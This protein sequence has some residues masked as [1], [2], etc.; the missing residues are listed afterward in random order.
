[1]GIIT[2]RAV[3][4]DRR[5]DGE[6]SPNSGPAAS[7]APDSAEGPSGVDRAGAIRFDRY[8]LDLERGCLMAGDE[9][10]ALRPKSF[11][12]LRYLASNPGRLVSKDELLAAVWPNV[13]VTEDSLVQ[14]VAELRRALCDRDQRLIRTMPRRGYRFESTTALELSPAASQVAEPPV[15]SE[16]IDEST[17]HGRQPAGT[18][19]KRR[20]PVLVAIGALAALATTI[21]IG[22]WWFGLQGR[23]TSA[24]PLSII[25][26]PFENF[27]DDPGQEHFANGVSSDLTTELSRLPGMFVISHATARTL[28]GKDIDPGQI[29]RELNVRY[30]LE[31]S[32][33]QTREQMRINV[34]LVDT[35]SGASAWADRFERERDQ[36]HPWGDEVIGRIAMTLYFRLTRLEGD[37]ALRER[38]DDPEAFDLTTRGWAL[39]YTANKRET[40]H[41]ARALFEQALEK[42][43]RAVN[44]LV[45][46]GWTSAVSVLDDWSASP[47]ADLATAESAV[48]QALALDPNHFIAHH[49]RGLTHRLRQRTQAARDA[50][51]TAVA[52]NPNWA[53]GYAQLAATALELGRPEET[54]AAIE[55]AIR[56]SPR[57]PNLGPWLANA[58]KAELHL[59]HYDE[60]ASWLARAIETGTPS[61]RNDA[62]LAAALALAGRADEARTALAKFRQMKPSAT[63][64]SLRAQARSTEPG[65]VTQQERFFEGLRLAGLPE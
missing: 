40:Y 55:R 34:Q 48:A 21:G 32:V 6:I 60:A 27:S 8:V 17:P 37:R 19:G 63:I 25:V 42:D 18:T 47:A 61:A 65:F 45:G 1:M 28:R 23:P 33:R 52:L 30:L 39:V 56:L 62:Y 3:P 57:D 36:L 31:G 14:C 41:T 9:E 44:A 29:G 38:G 58:G 7:Q 59:G 5:T 13:V 20:A 24:P 12:L 26:L 54:V 50:F 4:K 43:P 15:R 53:S 11:E 2:G 16:R 51:Q 35:A 46:I 64:A 10:I 49:V 22:W